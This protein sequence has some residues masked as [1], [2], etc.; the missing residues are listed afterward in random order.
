[1]ATSFES[2]SIKKIP[3]FPVSL[4]LTEL[5]YCCFEKSMS[6][7]WGSDLC[8]IDWQE[9]WSSQC[10][11]CF[12]LNLRRASMSEDKIFLE[13]ME[14][15]CM[16]VFSALLQIALGS[17]QDWIIVQFSSIAQSCPTLYNSMNCRM[18]GFP[19][20]HQPPELAQT[21][22]HRVGDAI[23]PSCPLTSPSPPAF[24][25]SHHQGNESV[26][27]KWV[28]SSHQVAKVLELQL[29][30]QSFQWIFRT[31]LL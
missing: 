19:V 16:T 11:S 2:K 7:T 30:R 10:I 8:L 17:T 1:M 26:L 22:V 14:K 27:F 23:Q 3:S 29:Q 6:K 5:L 24:K 12:W 9:S 15:W 4:S 13:N 21:H 25:L 28:S 18:P 31:D 20:H